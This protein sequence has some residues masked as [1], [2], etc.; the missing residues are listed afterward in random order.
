MT[1][2]EEYQH[3]LFLKRQNINETNIQEDYDYYD[4]TEEDN[5][6]PI[7]L[8]NDDDN[9]TRHINF[10]L[11]NISLPSIIEKDDA[12]SPYPTKNQSTTSTQYQNSEIWPRIRLAIKNWDEGS[13]EFFTKILKN[14]STNE[15]IKEDNNCDE[16]ILQFA[17]ISFKPD[18]ITI[19]IES[20][21]KYITNKNKYNQNALD[22]AIQCGSVVYSFF[23][24]ALS[25]LNI[26]TQNA[27]LFFNTQNK[28]INFK[29]IG[30]F[31]LVEKYDLALVIINEWYKTFQNTHDTL[32]K[33]E[34][35]STLS[36]LNELESEIKDQK[37]TNVI[38]NLYR[39]IDTLNERYKSA[40]EQY[41]N[42]ESLL[43]KQCFD[44]L[45]GSSEDMPV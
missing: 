30:S 8:E 9:Y 25:K 28:M 10:H 34:Y 18:A 27:V 4:Y 31:S 16:T 38:E 1:E 14:I 23:F 26:S 39:K 20:D 35:E 33:E 24:D 5:N 6:E 13:A 7:I 15:S 3:H 42:Q 21:L 2:E 22:Y 11:K 19:I 43:A 45:L 40:M 36:K 44:H 29:L 17:L 37:I 12:I 41:K 32:K